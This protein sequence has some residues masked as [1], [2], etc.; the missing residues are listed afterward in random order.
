[1]KTPAPKKS[2]TSAAGKRAHFNPLSDLFPESLPPVVAA[3]RPTAGTRAADALDACIAAPQNQAE[4]WQGWRL[5]AYVK[6]LEYL[7]WR[8]LK[9]DI[10]K[11]GCRRPITEYAI[12]R[13][14]PGTAA[15]LA[16]RQKGSI[17]STL[18]GLIAFGAVC[19]MLV[20]RW[21]L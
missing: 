17:D 20:A 3:V 9:R 16:S 1:M 2:G 4:Y 6:S 21:P 12:D 19:A 13:A 14:D 18:A 7:G 8:F 11:P 10:I 5:A 15:A